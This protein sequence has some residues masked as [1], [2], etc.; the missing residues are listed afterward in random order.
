M[1]PA[2]WTARTMRLFKAAGLYT[3][4]PETAAH[5][6]H[7]EAEAAEAAA[8]LYDEEPMLEGDEPVAPSPSA[9]HPEPIMHPDDNRPLQCTN[10]SIRRSAAQ[11]AGR[12]GAHLVHPRNTGRWKSIEMLAKYMGHGVDWR[13]KLESGGGTDPIFSVWV[14]KPSTTAGHTGKSAF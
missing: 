14:Y 13:A 3:P 9:A 4:T 8:E 12:C 7:E 10:Q 1:T 2:M 6:E 11:W 5:P